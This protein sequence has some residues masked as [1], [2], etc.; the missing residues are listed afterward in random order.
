LAL[1]VSAAGKTGTIDG[2]ASVWF[3]GFT[4]DAAAAVWCG[5]PRGGQKYPMRNM[6]INGKHYAQVYGATTAR[7][8]LARHDEGSAC[9]HHCQLTAFDLQTFTGDWTKTGIRLVAAT[10]LHH[11]NIN[12][13]YE[14]SPRP[15][16]S[17]GRRSHRCDA[18][19]EC[20]HISV[21]NNAVSSTYPVGSDS[22]RSRSRGMALSRRHSTANS[23]S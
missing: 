21:G 14:Y 4:P 8:D 2:N 20:Q 7:P 18:F 23:I 10:D 13:I 22:R 17:L 6:T 16:D 15:D 1:A 11:R 5:D 12:S 19:N 9:A 3:V